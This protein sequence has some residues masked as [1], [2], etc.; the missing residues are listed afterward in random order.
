MAR[1]DA[2]DQRG[3]VFWPEPGD[4]VVVGF[5]N[6][7][8]RQAIVLGALHGSAHAPP[9]AAGPP[10]E[11]NAR[12]AIVSKAGTVIGFDDDK[13]S[14]TIETPGK[15]RVVIDDA[16]RSIT[17]ADQHG[18]QITLDARGITLK[19]AGDLHLDASGDVVIKGSAVDVQ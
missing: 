16:A 3:V 18:N 17:L 12:R 15:N 14:V 5:V 11:G 8:P 2:G 7:D 9:A 10:S 19:S 4:E 13:R 6:G 1:P